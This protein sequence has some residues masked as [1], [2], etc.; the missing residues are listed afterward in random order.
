MKLLT[1]GDSSAKL[2]KGQGEQ[3]YLTAVLYLKPADSCGIPGVNLCEAA[4]P[5]CKS[6][7]LNTA[8][9]GADHMVDKKTGLNL[10]QEARQKRTEL[11]VYRPDEFMAQLRDEI[12]NFVKYCE[13]KKMRPAIRLNGTSDRDWSDIYREFP[14]VQFYEYTK[15]PTLAIRL[16]ELPNVSVTFSLSE[17]NLAITVRMLNKGINVAVVFD[18]KRG[19]QLPPEFHGYTVFDGDLTDNRFLDPVGAI[20]HVIGLRAKGKAIKDTSGFVQRLNAVA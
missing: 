3:G 17:V 18:T 15:R 6:G 10:V 19:Q 5:G 8:G 7:C 1:R 2:A 9:R 11:L 14:D 16:R 13:R 20:G 12:R 4:S